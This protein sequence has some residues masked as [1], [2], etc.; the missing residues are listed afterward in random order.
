MKNY[1]YRIGA[2]LF[3]MAL[4]VPLIRSQ[5]SVAALSGLV[6]DPSQASIAGAAVTALNQATGLSRTT[7]T[8]GSGYYSFSSLPVG[9]YEITVVQAGF[10][11]QRQTVM[12]DPSAKARQ[13]FQLAIAGASATVQVSEQ[14]PWSSRTTPPSA[15]WLRTRP[16]SPARYSCGI[17]TI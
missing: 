14:A 2:F 11:S 7:Q 12:L 10:G 1:F 3:C 8:D 13:D 16:S 15:P 17:G 5:A 4:A 9:R 6:T